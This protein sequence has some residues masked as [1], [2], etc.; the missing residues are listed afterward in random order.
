LDCNQCKGK[1]QAAGAYEGAC[2]KIIFDE[3]TTILSVASS[4][5]PPIAQIE[6]E[7]ENRPIAFELLF[8]TIW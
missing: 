3:K 2:A 8:P 7:H 6:V 4:F 5:S 1:N